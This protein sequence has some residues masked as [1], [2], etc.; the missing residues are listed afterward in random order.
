MRVVCENVLCENCRV[1][2]SVVKKCVVRESVFREK[3]H[4]STH[5]NALIFT[6]YFSRAIF[7]VLFYTC[8]FTE[9]KKYRRENVKL[10]LAI[11]FFLSGH[12]FLGG[13]RFSF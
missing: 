5:C 12:R 8:Y 9:S 1:K 11:E 13:A 6:C 2:K 3:V 4:V 7:R 10:R